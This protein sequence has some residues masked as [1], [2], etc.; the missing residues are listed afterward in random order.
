MTIDQ[1]IENGVKL[2]EEEREAILRG[3]GVEIFDRR[4]KGK[5]IEVVFGFEES[6]QLYKLETY[7][8]AWSEPYA[9]RKELVTIHTETLEY[10]PGIW[11]SYTTKEMK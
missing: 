4:N 7:N 2:T 10:L 8:I 3:E 6:P 9:V 11:G 5:H 1:K